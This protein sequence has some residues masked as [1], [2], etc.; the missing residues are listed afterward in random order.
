[1]SKKKKNIKLGIILLVAFVLYF[2][3]IFVQQQRLIVVKNKDIAEIQRKIEDETL[4]SEHLKRKMSKVNTDEYLENV[5][6][7][8]LGLVKDGER[9]FI[10]VNK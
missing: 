3:Y 10:D 8:K 4:K 1:M 7:E 5:A 2:S 9:V 6:R